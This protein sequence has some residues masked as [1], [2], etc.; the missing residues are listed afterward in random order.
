M[1][2]YW[3]ITFGCQMNKSD[4]E[5]I[6]T[7]LENIGYK[8]ASNINEA[9]L[10][11]V[12]MCSVRQSA[13]DR[14]YGLIPKFRKLREKNPNLKTIL[15]G[16][17]LKKDKP[18]F[19]KGFDQI[20]KFKDLFQYQPKYQNKP[21][22]FIPISNGCNWA[23]AYCVVPFTRGRLIC[24]DHKEILKTRSGYWDDAKVGVA[25]PPIELEEGTTSGLPFL[26]FVVILSLDFLTKLYGRRKCK[27]DLNCWLE[28]KN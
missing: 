18:K 14:V 22:V 13:V 11:V 28:I 5:R 1:R 23:C 8:N 17:V 6:A 25:G 4:S 27:E 20:L 16:C 3:V 7:V 21:V 15:T 24:R 26:F 2:K 19:A 12:N 10:I 9:D